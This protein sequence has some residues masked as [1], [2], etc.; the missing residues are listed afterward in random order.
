MRTY[1]SCARA[2]KNILGKYGVPLAV[3]GRRQTDNELHE[4]VFDFLTSLNPKAIFVN[5]K[6]PIRQCLQSKIA[7]SKTPILL[8][9]RKLKIS[10]EN[11]VDKKV[12]ASHFSSSIMLESLRDEIR[13]I[14]TMNGHQTLNLFDKALV[15]TNFGSNLLC[16][17]VQ[18]FFS[19]CLTLSLRSMRIE[20]FEVSINDQTFLIISSDI[21]N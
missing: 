21:V 12:C 1:Q 5:E 3:I 7:N 6:N 13:S 16:S 11:D 18:P 4:V 8:F 15:S 19:L 2:T 17:L 9:A 10:R 20:N 14:P